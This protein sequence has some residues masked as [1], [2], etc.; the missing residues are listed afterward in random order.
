MEFDFFKTGFPEMILH[1]LA[2]LGHFRPGHT[3]RQQWKICQTN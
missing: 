1:F 2:W 3:E